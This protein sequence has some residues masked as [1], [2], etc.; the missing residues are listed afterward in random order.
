MTRNEL[1][2]KVGK[3]VGVKFDDVREI[4]NAIFDIIQSSVVLGEKV[5]IVNFGTFAPKTHGPKQFYNPLTE[6]FTTLPE[7]VVP[8]FIASKSFKDGCQV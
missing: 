5:S 3:T 4:G 2:R 1:Y 7:R 6:E 8:K